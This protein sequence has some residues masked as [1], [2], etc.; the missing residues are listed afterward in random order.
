MDWCQSAASQCSLLL[1]SDRQPN[2]QGHTR[3]LAQRQPLDPRPRH[4]PPHSLHDTP[5]LASE[6][7]TQ[8]CIEA[9]RHCTGLRRT[10]QSSFRNI[11]LRLRCEPNNPNRCKVHLCHMAWGCMTGV[12][13]RHLHR[14]SRN[15][16]E[17]WQRPLWQRRAYQEVDPCLIRADPLGCTEYPSAVV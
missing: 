2:V 13:G 12:G 15:F 1:P 5:P 7:C 10:C 16:I 6:S 17:H 4:T 11:P 8:S 9:L 3:P 14:T